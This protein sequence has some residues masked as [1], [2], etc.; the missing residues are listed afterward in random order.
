M[1]ERFARSRQAELLRRIACIA[2][3]LLRLCRIAA[4][5]RDAV[6]G[7]IDGDRPH[8]AALC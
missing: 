4:I 5:Q 7:K 1:Q 2:N 6:V 8:R 3:G